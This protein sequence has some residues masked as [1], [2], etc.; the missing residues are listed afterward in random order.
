MF[1][2]YH[3]L[4]SYMIADEE[5]HHIVAGINRKSHRP[6]KTGDKAIDLDTQYIKL[7]LLS[8]KKIEIMGMDRLER[9]DLYQRILEASDTS[10]I[11][12]EDIIKPKDFQKYVLLR[13]RA[14]IGKSTL[15]QRLIWK[16]ANGEWATKFKVMF[17]LNLRYLMTIKKPMDMAHLLSGYSMYH[18]G[19]GSRVISTEWLQENQG[20]IV[21]FLGEIHYVI[22]HQRSYRSC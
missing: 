12:D 1:Q 17:L 5:I 13:G 20:S 14:G 21:L 3:E 18:T 10:D 22:V 15:V 4:D 2:L 8:N 7:K 19:S 9:P 16:W 6:D 11:Q